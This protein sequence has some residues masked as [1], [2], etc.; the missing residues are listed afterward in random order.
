MQKCD[1]GQVL[2]DAVFKHLELTERDYF[3][4][5]L[6]EDSSDTLVSLCLRLCVHRVC[7]VEELFSKVSLSMFYSA[8]STQASPSGSS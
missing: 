2:L 8:G 7:V 5:H 3:G 4:L 1:L 6:A